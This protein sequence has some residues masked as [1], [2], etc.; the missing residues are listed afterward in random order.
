MLA[1]SSMIFVKTWKTKYSKN[2]LFSQL[3]SRNRFVSIIIDGGNEYHSDCNIQFHQM[4][5]DSE[6][7]CLTQ[8]KTKLAMQRTQARIQT[9][10]T[11]QITVAINARMR[12]RHARALHEINLFN[13]IDFCVLQMLKIYEIASRSS[14]CILP[15]IFFC[16][17]ANFNW[18][19]VQDSM[20]LLRFSF[21]ARKKN[22]RD[23]SQAIL[24]HG[25]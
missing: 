22:A 9:S 25:N 10:I 3:T 2:A 7:F 17:F 19:Q 21:A 12:N 8:Y 18:L 15:I 23:V 6:Q 24:L 14:F 4:H 5:S 11:Q 16:Q 1:I 20:I 13:Q